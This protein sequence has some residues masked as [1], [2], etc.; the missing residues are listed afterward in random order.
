MSIRC[1]HAAVCARDHMNRTHDDQSDRIGTS[2]GHTRLNIPPAHAGATWG[3]TGRAGRCRCGKVVRSWKSWWKSAPAGCSSTGLQLRLCCVLC[4]QHA[5][6]RC[7]YL[8]TSL[9]ELS[10]L[11]VRFEAPLTR[12]THERRQSTDVGFDAVPAS[13][14][15]RTQKQ[16][17]LRVR[18][19]KTERPRAP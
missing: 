8:Q 16:F 6:A 12:R 17:L 4:M 18:V 2:H 14:D 1:A 19:D 5:M 9:R 7:A 10:T 15:H 13:A 3:A 11:R